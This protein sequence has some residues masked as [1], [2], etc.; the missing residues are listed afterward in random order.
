I[1]QPVTDVRIRCPSGDEPPFVA[2]D[3]ATAVVGAPNNEYLR[4]RSNVVERLKRRVDR[5]PELQR[6]VMGVSVEGVPAAHG[7]YNLMTC[8]SLSCICIFVQ[9]AP[10]TASA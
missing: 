2:I 1:S 5:Q 4:T 6:D 8:R 9:Y 10:G 3:K 7:S